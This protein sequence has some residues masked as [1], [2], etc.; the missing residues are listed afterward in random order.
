MTGGAICRKYRDTVTIRDGEQAITLTCI[1]VPY[2]SPKGLA[3]VARFGAKRIA[4]RRPRKP[5]PREVHQIRSLSDLD[6][7]APELAWVGAMHR[8]KRLTI[9]TCSAC[10]T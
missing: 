5:K 9:M 8:K 7:H 4:W 2:T 10:F 3:K 1:A 6:R